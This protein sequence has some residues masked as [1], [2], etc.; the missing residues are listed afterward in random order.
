MW[1]FLL[2]LFSSY[3]LLT[4]L[5]TQVTIIPDLLIVTIIFAS[6]ASLW[7]IMGYGFITGLLLDL[8]TGIGLYHTITYSLAGLVMGLI[9]STILQT[10]IAVGLVN[11]LLGTLIIHYGYAL[12]TKL[13]TPQLMLLP[14]PILLAH[15]ALNC[16]I[17]WGL[18][19]FIEWNRG[20]PD[21][22]R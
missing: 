15:L 8:T 12:L 18:L 17:V 5:G 1:R 22:I 16:S 2:S 19:T 3:L 11:T 7:R 9:P 13:F 4:V 20:K 6:N 10:N 21:E 14:W